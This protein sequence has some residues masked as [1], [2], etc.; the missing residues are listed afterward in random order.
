MED[1]E[2]LAQL[3]RRADLWME[4]YFRMCTW[5]SRS[6]ISQR[7]KVSM[8]ITYNKECLLIS[9]EPDVKLL[10]TIANAFD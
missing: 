7:R 2:F 1:W 5:H 4:R 10:M 8:W 3:G 6:T 9:D